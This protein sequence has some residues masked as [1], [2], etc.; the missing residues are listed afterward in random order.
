MSGCGTRTHARAV[1]AARAWAATHGLEEPVHCTT[2][3]SVPYRVR[4]NDVLIGIAYYF[5]VPLATIYQMNPRYAQG[6]VLRT[7]DLVRL[8]P[9]AR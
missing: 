6:A 8:P 2:G 9:P 3:V 7:G 5:G 1:S 4:T